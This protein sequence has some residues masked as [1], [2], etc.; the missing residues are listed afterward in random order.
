[1]FSNQQDYNTY[2]T[3]LKFLGW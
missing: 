2:S 1:M 3:L